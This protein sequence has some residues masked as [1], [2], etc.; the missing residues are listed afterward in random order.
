[1]NK[2]IIV[3]SGVF[4]FVVVMSTLCNDPLGNKFLKFLTVYSSEYSD[5]KFMLIKKGMSK[6]DVVKHLGEPLSSKIIPVESVW[7]YSLKNGDSY[8]ICFSMKQVKCWW[9]G[10]VPEKIHA[11][12]TTNQLVALM[13]Q[14]ENLIT[15]VS[16][17]VFEYSMPGMIE[18]YDQKRIVFL[19]DEVQ[20]V[21]GGLYFD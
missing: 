4:A 9:L 1:M 21:K 18:S 2:R 15:N 6:S 3:Y 17:Y 8:Q 13:G 14:P 11:V 19:N 7:S 10:D 20:E 5:R 16:L 12:Y